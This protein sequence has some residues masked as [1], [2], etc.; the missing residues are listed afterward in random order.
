MMYS[1]EKVPRPYKVKGFVENF[2][3]KEKYKMELSHHKQ[4]T[5]GVQNSKSFD[6]CTYYFFILTE[7]SSF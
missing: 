6:F 2:D 1:A 5:G 3:E 7:R 4:T